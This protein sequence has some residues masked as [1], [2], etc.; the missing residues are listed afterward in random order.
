[1]MD[2]IWKARRSGNELK[3]ERDHRTPYERD[4]AR[5]IHS[6]A[7]RRLQAKTQVLGIGEGDFHRTRLTHSMEVA[8][9]A[10]GLVQQLSQ[11]SYESPL[12]LPERDLIETI[13]IAHDFGHPPFGHSGEIALNYA[14]RE[15]G[16]FEGNGQSL[17]LLSRLETHTPPFGLDLTRRSLLGVLKYPRP[18]SEAQM[19]DSPPEA[20]AISL[21]KKNWKPPK[22]YLDT[23][24]EIVT[25]LLSPI[26]SLDREHFIEW[27]APPIATKHGKTKYKSFDCSIMEIADDIAYGVHDL[28]DAI[29][30][31]LVSRDDW[32]DAL[33]KNTFYRDWPKSVGIPLDQIGEQLFTSEARKIAIGG[34]VHAMMISTH[35]ERMGIFECAIL[36]FRA[37]LNQHAREFL[38][39]LQ[40]LISERVIPRQTVQSLEYRG[41]YMVAQ[42]FEALSSSPE[43]LLPTQFAESVKAANSKQQRNRIVCDYIAGMTDHYATRIYQRLFIPGMGSVFEKL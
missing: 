21:P 11:H 2:E 43:S 15:Y 37:V 38:S 33:Q 18:F 20:K 17:R 24:K 40:G 8:Q 34:I 30:L 25:W 19:F 39:V 13:A 9:I 7:F 5:L 26:S 10:T 16:G 27:E 29:A 14:M 6:K 28:E 3:R 41:R 12:P 42:L 1:M 4:R 23:E 36:D 31:G 32:N 35:C 22:C